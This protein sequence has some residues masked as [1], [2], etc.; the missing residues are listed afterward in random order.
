MTKFSHAMIGVTLARSIFSHFTYSPIEQ[1]VVAAILIGSI[2]P[3]FDLYGNK[4]TP[5]KDRT[6]LASHRGWTHHIIL[7]LLLIIAALILQIPMFTGFVIGY[8][9]HIVMDGFSG[10]GIPYWRYQDRIRLNLYKTGGL[11]E[12]IVLVIIVSI[13]LLTNQHYLNL[14]SNK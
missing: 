2:F 9:S 3:D 11:S 10:L 8:C 7:G 14:I 13:G 4:N 1:S 6:L 5:Y 12:Y